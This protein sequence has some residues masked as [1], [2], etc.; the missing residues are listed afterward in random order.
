[1]VPYWCINTA[2]Q[3][4]I[5]FQ[6]FVIQNLT[7]AM[8]ALEFKVTTFAGHLHNAENGL[9][10]MSRKLWVEAIL[11]AHD[12]ASTGQVGH[13]CSSFTSKDRVVAQASLL[14]PFN[15]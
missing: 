8:Q 9:R 12:K 3:T 7:H 11:G 14:R 15:L 10:I 6:H 4:R 13:I 5:A 2:F 1:M